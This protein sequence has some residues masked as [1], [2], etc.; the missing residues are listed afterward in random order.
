MDRG[1]HFPRHLR[2][3]VSIPLHP[4]SPSHR[5]L[6][7]WRHAAPLHESMPLRLRQTLL[8][9]MLQLG[10]QGDSRCH[11]LSLARMDVVSDAL[12]E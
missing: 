5:S 6:T 11:R 12:G 8:R 1:S 3:V 4:H 2:H 7:F 10:D 9:R